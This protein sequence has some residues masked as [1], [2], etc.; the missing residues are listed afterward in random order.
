L[1]KLGADVFVLKRVSI[2][3]ELAYYGNNLKD[4]FNNITS[5]NSL[6]I[7]LNSYVFIGAKIW[8]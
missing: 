4:M 7:G 5:E 3:V 1:I 8:L 6:D 2:G